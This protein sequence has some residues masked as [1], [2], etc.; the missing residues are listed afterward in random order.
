LNTRVI[1]ALLRLHLRKV[2]AD[3]SNI[4]WL[5][6]MPLVF[7]VL[8]G[9]MFGAFGSGRLP[10]FLVYDGDRSEA[11]AALAASL[12]DTSFYRVVIADTT[13]S[14]A[15]AREAVVDGYG[16]ALHI[17]AGF[18][19]AV[20]LA[21]ADSAAAVLAFHYDPD[22][23]SAQTA[24]TR[25]EEAAARIEALSAGRR[26]GGDGFASAAFDS[27]WS[28]PRLTMDVVPIGRRVETGLKLEHGNQ[29]VGPAYTLMFV[30]MFLLMSVK[31]L[32][33]E[34]E[35]RTL[36]RLSLTPVRPWALTVG[37]FLGP[38]VVGLVQMGVLL[39]LNSLVLGIDYGD[40]PATLVLLG[41]VFT[42]VFTALAL[43]LATLCRT[44]G[45]ADGVGMAAGLL[46]SALG[47]LWWPLEIVPELMR[48]IGMAL[49]TGQAIQIFHDLI[50]RGHGLADC[51][52]QLV[53]LLVL[54]LV[55]G[56]VAMRRLN[57]L[58]AA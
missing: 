18:A 11:S 43:L 50:G 57:R 12:A 1:L 54:V 41:L 8:M 22:R 51:A 26:A 14:A 2:A 35:N 19:Q 37:L 46:L 31:D 58:L 3:R 45:Q 34:R 38:L 27:L 4:V 36:T 21:R 48:R 56:A 24:R 6:L 39:A 44:P 55:F 20:A 52:D 13:G 5:L 25:V 33:I 7:S 42:A 49:P 53:Y 10:A 28:E 16:A 32:V 40:S 9:A 23:L 30:M 17:P 15:M 47:G 29:H